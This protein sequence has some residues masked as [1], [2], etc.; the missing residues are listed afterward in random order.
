MS[1]PQKIWKRGIR[2]TEKGYYENPYLTHWTTEIKAVIPQK[3]QFLLVL[4]RTYFY[5]EGGGQPFDRGTIDGIEVIDVFEKDDMIFHAVPKVPDN[6]KVDCQIHFKRRFEHMQQHTGE[7]ILAATF[8]RLYGGVSN[9]FHMGED[10]VSID[11]SLPEVTPAM[12]KEVEDAVNEVIYKNIPVKTYMKDLEG[13]KLLPLRKQPKVDEDIRIVEIEGVDFC[14][15]C[16]THVTSTGEVGLLKILKTEKSKG[17]TR[18]YFQCGRKALE[19]Y[20]KKHEIIS[21]L[22]E[23]FSANDITLLG[24]IE[25]YMEDVKKTEVQVKELHQEL[26]FCE[27]QKLVKDAKKSVVYGSYSNKTLNE[28]IFIAKQVAQMGGYVFIGVSLKEKKL[29]LSHNTDL[30]LH[31]GKL[32]KDVMKDF[33]ARGGGSATQ[34]QASFESEEEL[35]KCAETLRQICQGLDD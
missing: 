22:Y 29:L 9:A 2:M 7:H 8:Y 18:I 15:C 25:K 26:S 16:G 12:V 19:D 14:P 4:D 20:R 13:A 23:K 30:V 34:A 32:L 10:Y 11:I 31:C 1:R 17:M 35:K 3:D 27:A 5:P 33:N 6:S 21:F 24:K 28:I